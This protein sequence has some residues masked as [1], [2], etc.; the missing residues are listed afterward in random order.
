ML[1]NYAQ[2]LRDGT[3]RG[4][5]AEK[6]FC[7][8]IMSFDGKRITFQENVNY[9][10]NINKNADER[11]CLDNFE[12]SITWHGTNR[13]SA[14][15]NSNS[16]TI[17]PVVYYPGWKATLTGTSSDG[18]QTTISVPVHQFDGLFLGLETPDSNAWTAE[19]QFVPQ[20]VYIGALICFGSW[21]TLFFVV[22]IKN[23]AFLN[24]YF[25][26]KS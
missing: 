5:A 3:G 15:I 19:F 25:S 4:S 7:E 22:I 8:Q 1:K 17:F 11:E 14:V 13:F 9:N 10:V 12:S 18:K 20:S 24:A 16:K 2:F 6:D 26:K 23:R 21:L